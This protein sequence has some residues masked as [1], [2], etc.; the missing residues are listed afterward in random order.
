MAHSHNLGHLV[1][2][3]VLEV[4]NK[5]L[6]MTYTTKEYNLQQIGVTALQK[7]AKIVNGD[8]INI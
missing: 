5:D 2:L 1:S 7:M 4:T 6:K 3:L 8:E